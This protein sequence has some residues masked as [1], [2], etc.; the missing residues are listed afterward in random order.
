V[1]GTGGER[2]QVVEQ[3]THNAL[4]G[5]FL[6]HFIKILLSIRQGN[7]KSIDT[8]YS[9]IFN[10]RCLLLLMQDSKQL[11]HYSKTLFQVGFSSLKC[12]HAP[13]WNQS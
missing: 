8:I 6:L 11:L 7:S 1:E 4:I 12:L 9:G 5:H 2:D 3:E 10:Y 13:N